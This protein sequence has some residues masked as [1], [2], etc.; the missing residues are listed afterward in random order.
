MM[1]VESTA[2]TLKTTK[3]NNDTFFSTDVEQNPWCD[4]SHARGSW[5]LI[6]F[7]DRK[8]FKQTTSTLG[9]VGEWVMLLWCECVILENT[10]C[11]FTVPCAELC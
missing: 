10:C 11:V 5:M 1:P 3:Q 6:T 7:S 9:F 8:S 4:R 2:E